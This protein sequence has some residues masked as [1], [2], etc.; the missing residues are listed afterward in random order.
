MK[1]DNSLIIIG[2]SE[3]ADLPDFGI[4]RLRVKIDTGART[5]ALHVEDLII[6]N[7]YAE[8]LVIP[9]KKRKPVPVTAPII[10]RSRVKSSNG[11]YSERVF[12]ETM[13][14]IGPV[15]QLIE[16]SLVN[17]EKMLFPMLIGRTALA[18]KFLVDPGHRR[19]ISK[20]LKK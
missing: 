2:W 20:K 19:I 3:L 4:R 5:S 15:E 1:N 9:G 18:R 11:L 16:I 7:E 14:K 6:D 13:L 8:F 12:I 10:R 17:R